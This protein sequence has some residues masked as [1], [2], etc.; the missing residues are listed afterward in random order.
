MLVL[1]HLYFNMERFRVHSILIRSRI[2]QSLM[3]FISYDI[4]RGSWEISYI[5]WQTYNWGLIIRRIEPWRSVIYFWASIHHCCCNYFRP[6][7]WNHVGYRLLLGQKTA[8]NT[9]PKV[10]QRFPRSQKVAKFSLQ[11][12]TWLALRKVPWRIQ[13]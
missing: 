9:L 13:V 5:H 11:Q 2:W 4:I 8:T 10:K 7:L 1:W 6:L 12:W 3:L